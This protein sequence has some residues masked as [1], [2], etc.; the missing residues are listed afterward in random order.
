MRRDPRHREE[1][2]E[3]MK[4]SPRLSLVLV[5]GMLALAGLSGLMG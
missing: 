3:K 4:V 5:A 1:G 2:F